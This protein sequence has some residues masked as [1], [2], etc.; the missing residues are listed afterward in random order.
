MKPILQISLYILIPV[1]AMML[2]TTIALFKR[3]S[4]ALRSA[5][6]HFAAGVIF[7]VVAVELL[8]DIVKK[9]SPLN[10]IFGFVLG[11]LMMFLIKRFTDTK[12]TSDKVIAKS[13]L[14]LGLLVA[15][16]VD[17][18]IDGLLLGTGF[19]AGQKEGLLLAL[20]LGIELLSLGMATTSELGV[21]GITK[22]KSVGIIL[23]L[24]VLFFS[25]ALIGDTLLHNLSDRPM[26][27]VL[28]FGLSALLFLVTEE[29]LV[30]AHKEEES[31]WLTSA[32][33]AG[34]LLFLILGMV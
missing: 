23:I 32:F 33:F 16:G 10:V 1:F 28:S 11:L 14:P 13:Q 6:L 5:I 4:V 31:L 12:G 7:S 9:H 24:G 8:P 26:E 17:I 3:P 20:A 25:T 30:E 22:R 2:G 15:I 18:A 27:V 34:F 19:A 21:K 29:L